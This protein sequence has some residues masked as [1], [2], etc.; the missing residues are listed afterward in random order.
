MNP[1]GRRIRK[2][3][4]RTSLVTG[5]AVVLLIVLVVM[6]FRPATSPNASGDS[7][8]LFCAAGIRLPIE[9]IRRNFERECGIRVDVQYGGSNT[10]LSQL[11]VSRT[12]DLYLAADNAYLA[13]ARKK[14]LVRE[15]IPIANMVPVIAVPKGNPKAIS[16]VND[17]MRDGLRVA[18]GNP[19]QAAIGKHTR[20]ALRDSGQWDALERHVTE[21]GVFKPT[22]P[23][24]A[25]SVKIGSVDAGIVW[26]ATVAQYD[27]LDSIPA[28]ELNAGASQI[29]IGITTWSESAAAALKFARYLAGRNRGL[30]SFKEMGYEPVGG[31][32]WTMRPNLTFFAGSVNRRALE[33][34][35]KRFEV[36]E[37]VRVN[38]VYN[39][40]GILTAQMRAIGEGDDPG[41]PDAYL[42]CDV[43]YLD[44]VSELFGAGTR[45]S[46]TDIVL[47]VAEGNPKKIRGLEDLT[48][49]GVR[50]AIGQP[51]QCAIGVL[52]RRLLEDANLY[53]RV[54]KGNV[55]TETASSAMLVPAV[56]TGSADVTLAYR[57]DT[58]AETAHTDILD[59]DSK[60][61]KAIQPFAISLGTEH[62]QLANRLFA[63]I[64]AARSDFEAAGFRWRLNPDGADNKKR[65]LW[66]PAR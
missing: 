4:R 57:T 44:T 56:T 59:I 17:L 37:G 65:A 11:Q 50:V 58:L 61:A 31:D 45:I 43:Y 19:G 12:A 5:G 13:I 35:I 1:N 9:Q 46:E 22:V 63:T 42:A 62:K 55:V 52:S 39:G 2:F 47:V 41:F 40:C 16:G 54:R 6:M 28:P 38:T 26:D 10:L 27:E 23:D 32:P 51:D 18:L 14:G 30:I 7:L 53:Q 29:T 60:L 8:I 3:A 49:E 48:R 21:S 33:P 36:R 64:L 15:T 34:A 24:V 66:V 25:N 20:K